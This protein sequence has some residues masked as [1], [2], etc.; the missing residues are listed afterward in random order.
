MYIKVSK[1]FAAFINDT[2]AR[3]GKRFAASVVSL[4]PR[5]ALIAGLVPDLNTSDFDAETGKFKAIIVNY[6]PEFYACPLYLSTGRLVAEFRRR[7]VRDADGLRA[8]IVDLC[9]V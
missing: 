7:G 8:M 2:A 5:A 3:T 1:T 6:P 4:S 9:E